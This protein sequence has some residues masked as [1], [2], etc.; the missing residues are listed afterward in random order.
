[1]FIIRIRQY[2]KIT[3]KSLEN[4][5]ITSSSPYKIEVNEVRVVS[6]KSSY[7]VAVGELE[8]ELKNLK[9]YIKY[10]RISEP[11]L[12][13]M[14]GYSNEFKNG[15]GKIHIMIQLLTENLNKKSI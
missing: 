1:M 7:C 14:D 6:Y 9:E 4:R 12:N 5:D 2:S 8:K 13:I 11:T 10:I 15:L 3:K